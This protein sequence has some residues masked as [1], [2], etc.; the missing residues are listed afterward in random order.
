M[1]GSLGLAGI[2]PNELESMPSLVNLNED[3]LMSGAS[4]RNCAHNLS[5]N[6]KVTLKLREQVRSYT[7]SGRG[8]RASARRRL[9]PRKPPKSPR[10]STGSFYVGSA[11]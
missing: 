7:T 5:L 3:P 2:A 6:I 11:S 4:S 9:G 8:A 1:L 10:M